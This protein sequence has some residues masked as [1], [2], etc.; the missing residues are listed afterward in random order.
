MVKEL[1]MVEAR[2]DSIGKRSK[3]TQMR[4]MNEMNN[5]NGTWKDKSGTRQISGILLEVC[6]LLLRDFALRF[7][8]IS[9]D[10]DKAWHPYLL[11]LEEG[12]EADLLLYIFL[13]KY[14]FQCKSISHVLSLSLRF[15]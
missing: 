6:E 2:N 1:E 13:Y 7:S 14:L 10:A 5:V 8:L 11:C 9:A 4:L 3:R 12:R 15:N